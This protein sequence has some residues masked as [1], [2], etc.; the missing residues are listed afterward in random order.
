M[1]P[2]VPLAVLF[3]FA[4]LAFASAPSVG[5]ELP[6]TP[7]DDVP[8][9]GSQGLPAI[10][11]RGEDAFAVWNDGRAGGIGVLMGS[12]VA[13]DGT[14]LDPRGLLLDANAGEKPQIVWHGDAYLILSGEY[15]TGASTYVPTWAHRVSP[16]GKLLERT[17]IGAISRAQL[18]GNGRDAVLTGSMPG[19]SFFA[20]LD[21]NGAIREKLSVKSFSGHAVVADGDDWLLFLSRQACEPKCFQGLVQ[22]RIRDGK[23]VSEREVVVPLAQLPSRMTAA[24]D[25]NGRF[26][27][28]WNDVTVRNVGQNNNTEWQVSGPLRYIVTDGAANVIRLPRVA[29]RIEARFVPRDRSI[30]YFGVSVE[31]PDVIWTGD[32]FVGVWTWFDSAGRSEVRAMSMQADGTP[33]DRDP[34]VVDSITEPVVTP[35]KRPVLA[36]TSSRLHIVWPNRTVRRSYLA[37]RSV[38][39]LGELAAPGGTALPLRTASMQYGAET[40]ASDEAVFMV[41]SETD[42]SEAR[43]RGRI[44]GN[45]GWQSPVL[46]V[47]QSEMR[48]HI[49]AVAFTGGVWLVAWRE[50]VYRTEANGEREHYAMRVMARRFDRTGNALDGEPMILTQ[51]SYSTASP[52]YGPPKLSIAASGSQ[53]LVAWHGVSAGP[54]YRQIRVMRIGA[55]GAPIDPSPRYVAPPGAPPTRGTPHALWTGTDYFLLWQEEILAGGQPPYHIARATRV[56]VDGEANGAFPE[57]TRTAAGWDIWPSPFETATNGS[58]ILLTW[59]ERRYNTRGCVYAQRFTFDGAPAGAAEELLCATGTYALPA[60]SFALWDG[61]R[62]RVFYSFDDALWAHT[63]DGSGERV[64]VF[65]TGGN[66]AMARPVRTA[67]GIVVPYT[68]SDTEYGSIPRLFRRTISFNPP[69]RRS[70]R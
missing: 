19:E 60:R 8:L 31:R 24:T 25:G 52:W 17:Y 18:F 69:R 68:R 9:F 38:S 48:A 16:E 59:S 11:S 28:F 27:L 5:P 3:L 14:L 2:R 12:R 43:L 49:P 61:A 1:S 13:E 63:I 4:R 57:L 33:I 36:A 64:K 6:L 58:E 65:E 42:G 41:W 39:S 67:V 70:V 66:F 62:F 30:A 54:D 47:S 44:V 51:E 15:G 26:L 29:D 23:F 50:E 56:S 34:L 46:D 21:R 55:D 45:T 37:A 40:G 22:F 35:Q 32:R 10:A 53:F 7:V 20:L